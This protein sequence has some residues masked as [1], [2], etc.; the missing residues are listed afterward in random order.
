MHRLTEHLKVLHF[1]HK[2]YS[3]GQSAKSQ[4]QITALEKY[5]ESWRRPAAQSRHRKTN[6][7][8]RGKGGP[9][10]KYVSSLGTNK[11]MIEGPE[12]KNDCAGEDLQQIT[13]PLWSGQL[14]SFIFFY[15]KHRRVGWG[16]TEST[17]YVGY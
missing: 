5:G 6:P 3:C 10:S 13:S 1:A 8:S 16:E 12:T 17:W 9:I 2:I 7:S 11:N 4:K 15:L 14:F